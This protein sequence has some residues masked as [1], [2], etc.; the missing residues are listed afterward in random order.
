MEIKAEKER[1]MYKPRIP[2]EEE[3]DYRE[4]Y[5]VYILPCRFYKP[6]YPCVETRSR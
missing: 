3:N 1:K 4:K 2:R 5:G 6:K